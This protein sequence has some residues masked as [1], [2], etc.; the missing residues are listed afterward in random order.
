MSANQDK[1]KISLDFSSITR[2]KYEI[3]VDVTDMYTEKTATELIQA[4]IK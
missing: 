2:G 1:V 4:E 3:I